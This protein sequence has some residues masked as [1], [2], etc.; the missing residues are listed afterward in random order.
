M[1]HKHKINRNPQE[2]TEVLNTV[3]ILCDISPT[4]VTAIQFY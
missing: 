1:E 2:L 3:T 4:V